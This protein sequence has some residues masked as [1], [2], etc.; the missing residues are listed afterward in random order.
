MNIQGPWFKDDQGRTLLLR[1]VNLG[2]SSKIPVVPDGATYQSAGF[3]NHRQV[4]FVGRPFPLAEADEHFRRL[5]SWGM[6]FLRF[7]VTWEAIEHAGPGQYDMEYLD[8]VHAILRKANDYGIQVFIDPHQDVWSRF[9]GGDGAPG[10][11]LEAAG[12]DLQRLSETGA[13]IVHQVHGDPFP[14]MIWPSNSAKL[15]S[16]TMFTLFFAGNDFAPGR[17]PIGVPGESIQ[18]YLQRH[19]VRAIQVLAERLSDLPNV[20]GYDTLNEPLPGYIGWK[21]AARRD[22][23]LQTG[24]SPTP[25]QSML[26]G[27][28]YPQVVD[29]MER[30]VFGIR[31][32]GRKLLNP[33]GLSAWQAGSACPWREQG[34]W[35]VDSSGKPYLI[36]PE[37]F[38]RIAGHE[39]NFENDYLRPFTTKVAEAVHAIRPEA[40]IFLEGEAFHEP[41]CWDREQRAQVVFTPHWYDAYVL[42]FKAFSPWLGVDVRGGGKLVA[43]EQAIRR[44]FAS[45]IGTFK[46]MSRKCLGNAPVFLGEFGTPF[47]LDHK[48]AYHNG[49]FS[50]QAQALNRTFRALE[51]N[52]V[53]YTIWN[54][55]PDNNNRRGDL[56]ND[57]DLSI[58]SRD[59]QHDQGNINSGG[60]ALQSILRP[61][62]RSTAGEPL[63]LEFDYRTGRME[64][65]FRHA[66]AIDAPTEFYLPALQYPRGCRVTVSDGDYR[67]DLANQTMTYRHTDRL[68]EHKIVLQRI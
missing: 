68:A 19:Y 49:D 31:R 4:S 29:V 37:Y 40:L 25:Y 48:H 15:A 66:P 64:Y 38:R 41:P 35:E 30:Q 58:F 39:V 53:S 50:R 26:L 51:D 24:P 33:G 59:Q 47:D 3:F 65:R 67:L 21:D 56:W 1:G 45:Q 57:E 22:G 17:T 52:L 9:S 62:P 18:D 63:F 20:I 44:S 11:T 32:V 61:F 14:R 43:G 5:K 46:E 42:F 8:Y 10:W 6:T 27:S 60:R 23:V 36:K 55:N 54:Y 13:A 16:S 7:L 34:I 2:G 12:F 28:G